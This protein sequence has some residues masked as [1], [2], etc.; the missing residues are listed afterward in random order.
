MAEA[1]GLVLGVIPLVFY[2]LDKYQDCLEFGRSYARYKDTLTSIRDD[3]S[4]QQMLFHGTME[5]MGLHKPT[6]AELEECLQ[7]RFPENHMQFMRCIRK[8]AD[9]I[10]E[11]MAKLEIDANSKVSETA[12]TLDFTKVSQAN[13]RSLVSCRMGM[14]A[15]QEKPFDERTQEDV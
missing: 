7:I 11:L 10:G 5:T 14:A 9:T 6:Y 15:G 2:A 13:W 8:M 12:L 4:V 3:V 1:A